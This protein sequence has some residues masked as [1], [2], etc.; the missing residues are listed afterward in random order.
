MEIHWLRGYWGRNVTWVSRNGRWRYS[1]RYCG[2]NHKIRKKV[3]ASKRIIVLILRL[4]WNSRNPRQQH[5]LPSPGWNTGPRRK[6]LIK[7]SLPGLCAGGM[8]VRN[9][10]Q[11]SVFL[12]K[13]PPK[14]DGVVYRI[15]YVYI[16]E[17]GRPMQ[18]WIK[19]YDREIRLT[20]TQTSA[21]S[22][23]DHNTWHQP[24]WN[25]IKFIDGDPHYY[26]RRV[27]GAIHIRLHS[28]NI[29]RD[30]GIEIPEAWMHTTREKQNNRRA[31]R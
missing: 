13:P 23:H 1:E 8:F 12:L 31:V 2:F 19:E 20:H 6:H 17:T 30:G 3:K 14:Q 10:S 29:N 22:E 18:D 27:K 24:L 21:V 25:E 26:T 9:D 11:Y 4:T 5:P 15:P 28:D 16:V 7:V